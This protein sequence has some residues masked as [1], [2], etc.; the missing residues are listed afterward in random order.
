MLIR[1]TEQ[2][3]EMCT[4]CM[5]DAS[6]E[7]HSMKRDVFKDTL[8]FL[9]EAK[10]KVVL[11]SGGEP[12]QHRNFSGICLI[13]KALMPEAVV[14]LLTNGLFIYNKNKTE[15]IRYLIEKGIS[16]SVRTHPK[17]YP[18]YKRVMAKSAEIVG[19][20]CSMFDDGIDSLS[21]LGRA[22]KNH[23]SYPS[24]GAQCANTVLAAKQT[25]DGRTWLAML[26]YSAK[27]YC[28]PS[29]GIDGT[30]YAG[31]TQFCH[32]IGHVKESTLESLYEKAKTFNPQRCDRCNGV[33]KVRITNGLAF[34][35]LVSE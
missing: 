1:I 33:E 8:R 13:I 19:L 35:L 9:M 4:H 5:I 2:C 7:G 28:K 11:I 31:E 34:K 30:I 24:K 14:C 26:E 29:I 15:D 12:T 17:F 6:P 32:P 10:P 27:N 20:G 18:S 21:R 23:Q 22:K 3:D 25:K 16:V